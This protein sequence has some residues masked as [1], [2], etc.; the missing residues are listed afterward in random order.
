MLV[1]LL[2]MN[3]NILGA[4]VNSVSCYPSRKPTMP[5]TDK[6]VNEKKVASKQNIDLK[7]YFMLRL[8]SKS[9]Y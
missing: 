9:K 8:Q 3:F 1:C 7:H 5:K 4:F 2:Y 6:D